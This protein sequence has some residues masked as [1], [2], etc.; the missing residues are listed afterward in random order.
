MKVEDFAV[1]YN[2]AQLGDKNDITFN[3]QVLGE[4]LREHTLDEVQ[5]I[6]EEMCNVE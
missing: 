4:M 2:F 3:I 1:K 5:E 6:I